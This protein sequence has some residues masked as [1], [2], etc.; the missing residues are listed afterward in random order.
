MANGIRQSP[1]PANA[2][3]PITPG[4]PIEFAGYVDDFDR[5]ICAMEFSLDDGASWTA[6]PTAAVDKSRGVNW[7]FVY[8]PEIPWA[9]PAEG[10]AVTEDGEPSALVAGFA[11][12]ALPPG[13]PLEM[14]ASAPWAA[15]SKT[16][17]SSARGSCRISPARRLPSFL[18]PSASPPFTTCARPPRWRRTPGALHRG[19]AHRGPGA[20]H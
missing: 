2:A 16:R 5:A 6:Y 10:A 19:H 20:L 7:R 8:T 12:E 11:F 17:A 1:R 13:A 18:R 9:L 15:R 3:G 4:T 14:R